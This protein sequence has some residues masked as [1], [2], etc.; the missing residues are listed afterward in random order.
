MYY[1]YFLSHQ[2]L[3]PLQLGNEQAEFSL[4]YFLML[5]DKA[6]K[7]TGMQIDATEDGY[8]DLELFSLSSIKVLYHLMTRL[9]GFRSR[10]L[11][12]WFAHY[13]VSSHSKDPCFSYSDF[14][15]WI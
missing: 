5:Q 14:N 13:E 10:E 9:Y 2:L 11:N 6:R 1:I 4:H 12:F 15:E 7:A 8:T 3:T